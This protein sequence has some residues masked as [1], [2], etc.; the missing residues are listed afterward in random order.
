MQI[1]LS[2]GSYRRI[3]LT[4]ELIRYADDFIVITRS[5]NLLYRY[6]TPAVNPFLK[7][8]KSKQFELKNPNTQL[9]FLGYTFKY[10][11]KCLS[12]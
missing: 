2:D 11:S 12:P 10:S 9:D 4:T 6:I 5:K 3:S 8:K 7:D 1:K